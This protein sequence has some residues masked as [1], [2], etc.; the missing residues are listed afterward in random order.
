MAGNL[1]YNH[2]VEELNNQLFLLLSMTPPPLF[3][4]LHFVV[5]VQ[6]IG[7]REGLLARITLLVDPPLYTQSAADAW[8]RV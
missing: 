5:L 7:E 3:T 2:T 1:P 4:S 6:K 8:F